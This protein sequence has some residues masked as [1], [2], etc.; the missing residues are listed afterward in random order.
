MSKATDVK[1]ENSPWEDIFWA[2]NYWTSMADSVSEAMSQTLVTIT[3]KHF[4]YIRKNCT[5]SQITKTKFPPFMFAFLCPLISKFNR[6]VS[7]ER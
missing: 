1:L 3:N 6:L 2:N 5:V 7:A 4:K